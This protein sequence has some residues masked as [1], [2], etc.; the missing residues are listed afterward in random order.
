ML[1]LLLMVLLLLLL[2]YCCPAHACYGVA[3]KIFATPTH[4]LLK[5]AH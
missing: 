2:L 4:C 5:G 1:I 3:M